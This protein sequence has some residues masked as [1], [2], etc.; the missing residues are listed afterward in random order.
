MRGIGEAHYNMS[1]SEG[2]GCKMRG[3][4][5]NEFLKA[6]IKL[7]LRQAV[8][9]R[10]ENWNRKMKPK[11]ITTRFSRTGR[12]AAYLNGGNK[13]DGAEIGVDTDAQPQ[14]PWRSCMGGKKLA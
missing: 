2:E 10:S 7:R 3:N 11:N 5:S 14:A 12:V 8:R 6:R 13:G 4:G 1:K 9:L